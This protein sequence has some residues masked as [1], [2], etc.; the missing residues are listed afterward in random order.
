M[1]PTLRYLRAAIRPRVGRL[2]PSQLRF[3]GENLDP[4]AFLAWGPVMVLVDLPKRLQKQDPPPS[5]ETL[6]AGFQVIA[7]EILTQLRRSGAA[8]PD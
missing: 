2:S 3:V 7:E 4:V 5:L 1:N 8:L 6:N